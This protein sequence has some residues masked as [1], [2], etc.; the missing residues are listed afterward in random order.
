[1]AKLSPKQE[2]FC[3]AYITNGGNATQAAISAGYSKKTARV[4]GA[5]NLTKPA[6]KARL[7]EQQAKAQEAFTITVEQRLRLLSSVADAGLSTYKDQQENLRPNNLSAVVSAV[8]EM[9][10]MLGTT[11]GEEDAVKP[12]QVVFNVREPVKPE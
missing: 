4:V 7:A 9:N 12:I 6:I 11:T 2:A 5:E 8:S 10:K 1:M 3:R